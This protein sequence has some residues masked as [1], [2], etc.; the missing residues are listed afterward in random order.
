M[1]RKEMLQSAQTVVSAGLLGEGVQVVF[2]ATVAPYADLTNRVMHLRPLPDEVSEEALLHL[3]ADC[4]HEMGHFGF[5]DPKVFVEKLR[6]LVKL[7]ANSIE[8]GFIERKVSDRW[9][10]CAQNLAG[11]NEKL[12]V[13]LLERLDGLDAEELPN[14]HRALAINGLQI[15]AFG[16]SLP[17]VYEKLGE[18]IAAIYAPVADILPKLAAV[19]S[20]I[21]SLRL[22]TQLVERWQWEKEPPPAP[23][24]SASPSATETE[25][26]LGAPTD[27]EPREKKGEDAREAEIAA[28][29][30]P[31]L[32]G[33][34]RKAVIAEHPF[35]DHYRY[36]AYTDEDVVE[37]LPP[38]KGVSAVTAFVRGVRHV[39]PPLRKRL[40][41]E[42]TGIGQRFE[43]NRR[44]GQ[45][46]QRA[47]HK[48]ALGSDRV[49]RV[50]VPEIVLDADI[51]LLVDA[52]GSMLGGG[53]ESK[54]HIA[55]QTACA[56]SMVLD[57]I[58]VSHECAAFTTTPGYARSA[59]ADIASYERVRPLRHLIVKQAAATFRQ[60]RGGFAA[61][62]AH[63]SC[64]EN[65]DGEAVM[66][67][68]RRLAARN[69]PGMKAVLI[70]ISDGVPASSPEDHRILNAHLKR[71]VQRVEE[72]GVLTLAIGIG[73]D[74][75]KRFY[76]NFTIIEDVSDLVGTGYRAVRAA[77]RAAQR[78]PT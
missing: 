53:A 78:R 12:R 4:D 15:L 30:E 32:L 31:L 63:D 64:I 18:E 65:I 10:G 40:I 20:T 21:N 72:A 75:V 33:A 38:E 24:T 25:T 60:C 28:A 27:G 5:T 26:G 47:L 76:K 37:T 66:W 50:K 51:T 61:L 43:R 29:V 54:L 46:D 11:S 13:A 23:H 6:P 68:A 70:V 19:K 48:I 57:H 16:G 73:T 14:A 2:D 62:A 42:F 44:R 56:F 77:L 17:E 49:F 52:S 69:R 3:R 71:T 45:L 8:D 22:A 39:V 41:M 9:L 58:G 7:V 67:A 55:A 35:S 34:V 74:S 36:R 1:L 59:K